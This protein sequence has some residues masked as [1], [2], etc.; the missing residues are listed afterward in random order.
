MYTDMCFSRIKNVMNHL[1]FNYFDVL[2]TGC[3]FAV[4]INICY[5][6]IIIFSSEGRISH[7]DFYCHRLVDVIS[8]L[9]LQKSS[10]IRH[11]TTVLQPILEK[12][13]IDHSIV[14]RVFIEYLTIADKVLEVQHIT[15]YLLHCT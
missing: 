5:M 3:V 12:G 6:R 13:I 14:H 4:T 10:V 15:A 2:V 8:K 1:V 11:M 7:F 9:K